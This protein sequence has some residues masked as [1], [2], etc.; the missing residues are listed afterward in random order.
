[1][2]ERILI[3]QKSRLNNEIKEEI[4]NKIDCEIEEKLNDLTNFFNS[5]IKEL[6]NIISLQNCEKQYSKRMKDS[7]I[8]YSRSKDIDEESNES[9][10]GIKRKSTNRNEPDNIFTYNRKRVYFEILTIFYITNPSLI[11]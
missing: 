11:Y 1:M 9:S 6:E 4:N 5:K 2:Q 7:P 8:L 3:K 10:E